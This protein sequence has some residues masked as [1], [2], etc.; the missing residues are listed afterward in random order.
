MAKHFRKH[1][2]FGDSLFSNDRQYLFYLRRLTELATTMFEWQ[3]LPETIDERFLELTLFNK[4]QAVFFKDEVLGFLCLPTANSGRW[5]IYNIPTR[6]RAY[7]TNGYQNNLTDK[8]SVIIYNNYLHTNGAVDA[9]LYARKLYDI[10]ETIMINCKAQKTPILIK[11]DESQRLTLLNLYKEYTGN[12]P[13]VYGDKHLNDDSF[14]VLVTGAPY[15]ADKLQS[16]K[17]QIWNEYLTHL[18]ISNVNNQKKE[19]LI[20]D[21]V[22][23]E[24]G[25]IIAS[26][27]SRLDMRRQACD[28]I[29]KMF[30]LNIWVDYKDDFRETDDEFM[31]EGESGSDEARR[32][33]QDLR[34]NSTGVIKKEG[35]GQV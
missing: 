25:G 12:A 16:L 15:V 29:N 14:E 19:R 34:S 5:S 20:T 6:R 33:V 22:T 1:T 11:C 21:E 31:L 3:N 4:A 23:R 8:D 2:E 17:A 7:A 13:V 28:Q 24:Q 32:M 26:R 35:S 30:N 27:Y 9:E 10:D 18:G